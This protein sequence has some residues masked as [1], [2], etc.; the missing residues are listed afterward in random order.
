MEGR[1]YITQI[2]PDDITVAMLQHR[3]DRANECERRWN[4]IRNR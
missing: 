4:D 1:P 2:F 3:L